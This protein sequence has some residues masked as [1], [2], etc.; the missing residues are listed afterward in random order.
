MS[1]Q[2]YRFQLTLSRVFNADQEMGK[3]LLKYVISL[4]KG[5]ISLNKG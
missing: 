2:S 3:C 4:N 1:A 5:L